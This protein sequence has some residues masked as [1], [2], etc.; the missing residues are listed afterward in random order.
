MGDGHPRRECTVRTIA[1]ALDHI[2][3]LATGRVNRRI[4]EVRYLTIDDNPVAVILIDN[5]GE[6]RI[7]VEAHEE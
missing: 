4:A 6:G 7:F 5:D 1:K 3:V 2:R